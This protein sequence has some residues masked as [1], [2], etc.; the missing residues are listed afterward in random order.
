MTR[1]ASAF[2]AALTIFVVAICVTTITIGIVVHRIDSRPYCPT[3][4]S[5]RADY[6][7]GEYVVIEVIP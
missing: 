3:E 7:N 5:C 6:Q 2:W 4:D 1:T